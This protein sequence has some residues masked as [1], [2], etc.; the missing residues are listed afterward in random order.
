MTAS[1]PRPPLFRRLAVETAAGSQI[2][3]PLRAHWRGV[4]WFTVLAFSLVAALAA[5][6][7]VAE[8]APVH[9]VPAYTDAQG[10]LIRLRS[11]ADGLA[12]TRIVVAE[13]DM[14]RRGS[15]LAVL[16][17]DRRRSDGVTRRDALSRRIESERSAIGREIDAARL[18]AAAQHALIDR[19]IAGLHAERQA[20][21][22]DLRSAQKLLASLEAQN[23]Q[24]AAVAAQGYATRLQAS[25]ARNEVTAQASR[26]AAARASLARVE[27]E[28][29]LAGSE[30][31]LVD[32]RLAGLVQNR[33]RS[34][35]EL[36]R[37]MVA[38]G[39]DAEQAVVAP[40]DGRVA[41][42]V[43]AQ[44]QS[45]ALGQ[46]L[47]TIVP[48]GEPLVLRLLVPARAAA[49]VRPGVEVKFALRAYPQE[50]FGQFDAR[51]QGVS[52]APSMPDELIQAGSSAEPVYVAV[53]HLPG[54]VRTVSGVALPL[55]PGML[56]EALVPIERRT[57]AEWLFEPLLRGFNEAA[58]R[59][60][61][62]PVR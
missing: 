46:T 48:Q 45:L 58:G 31:H 14:V 60:P 21:Q 11:P 29:D 7:S 40:N 3:E 18:E 53:A 56:A 22:E 61:G 17:S 38:E 15:L 27:R 51:I 30:R 34:S 50:K 52:D 20:L 28:T 5:L 37:L 12:A 33:R 62:P 32:A 25:Q 41:A 13:G 36:D 10:G 55:K 19:R 9:R 39:A 43:V 57:I 42:V 35:S 16:S 47:F 44:G 1:K 8:Y 49:A 6:V 2:G 24:L 23:E 54:I 59:A 4:R 26:V